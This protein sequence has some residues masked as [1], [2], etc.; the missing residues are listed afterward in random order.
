MKMPSG[1]PLV[2]FTVIAVMRDGPLRTADWTHAIH[3]GRN[4]PSD[5]SIQGR[6]CGEQREI[7]FF[8]RERRPSL[9]AK[10]SIQADQV[11]LLPS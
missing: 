11:K 2:T 7:R 4:A 5:C 1:P 3:T 6:L 10:H 9:P 8:I